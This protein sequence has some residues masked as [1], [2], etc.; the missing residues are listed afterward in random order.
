VVHGLKAWIS[1]QAA[2][3]YSLYVWELQRRGALHLHYAVWVPCPAARLRLYQGFPAWW[4]RRMCLLSEASGVDVFERDGGKGTWAGRP[5]VVQARAE[6]CRKTISGYLAKYVS[7]GEGKVVG[8]DSEGEV[9]AFAPV[10]W[11]GVSR[12]LLAACRKYS[13]S[14]ELTSL[15]RRQVEELRE[16]I[17]ERLCSQ[18]YSHGSASDEINMDMDGPVRSYRDKSG[19][20]SVDVAYGVYRYEAEISDMLG[21]RYSNAG[22][23]SN[24]TRPFRSRAMEPGEVGPTGGADRDRDGAEGGRTISRKEGR[25]GVE[26]QGNGGGMVGA[27]GEAAGLGFAELELVPLSEHGSG[28][29]RGVVS[30]ADKARAARGVGRPPVKGNRENVAGSFAPLLSNPVVYGPRMAVPKCWQ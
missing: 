21:P 5:D 28:V 6:V 23:V 17:L 26:I 19:A 20:F 8:V 10:R 25:V 9:T 3:T 29:V 15:T 7:K 24:N 18:H 11:W 22:S 16:G 14:V 1:K 2:S 12:P 4:Y 27:D 30:G 13:C